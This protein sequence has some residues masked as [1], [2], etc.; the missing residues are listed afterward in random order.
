MALMFIGG[1]AGSTAG[2]H[3][4]SVAALARRGRRR[5]AGAPCRP[6]AQIDLRCYALTVGA[7]II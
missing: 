4:N 5:R 7:A 3:A 6:P 1:A 2:D